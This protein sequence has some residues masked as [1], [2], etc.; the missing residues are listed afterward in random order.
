MN[1]FGGYSGNPDIECFLL[2]NEAYFVDMVCSHS[3]LLEQYKRKSSEVLRIAQR[4]IYPRIGLRLAS[5]KDKE[6]NLLIF[7]PAALSLTQAANSAYDMGR[8]SVYENVITLITDINSPFSEGI[9]NVAASL[10][11]ALL[12]KQ[13]PLN[14]DIKNIDLG[15]SIEERAF[16]DLNK[17][18]EVFNI[19]KDGNIVPTDVPAANRAAQSIYIALDVDK[20][21]LPA[22]AFDKGL[23]DER[24]ILEKTSND[25]PYNIRALD[26]LSIPDNK[27]AFCWFYISGSSY[28]AANPDITG[29]KAS[30]PSLYSYE[31]IEETFFIKDGY[32]ADDII[33]ILADRINDA[34]LKVD[35][36]NIVPSSNLIVSPNRGELTL[37]Y[38]T[39]PKKKLYPEEADKTYDRKM[40]SFRMLQR[41]NYL[42]FDSRRMSSVINRELF[43]VRFFTADKVALALKKFEADQYPSPLDEQPL[44]S[45]KGQA[46]TFVGN[47]NDSTTYQK[48]DLVNFANGSY[49]ARQ[50]NTDKD[51]TNRTWNSDY[52]AV[53][54]TDATDVS[55]Y[56]YLAQDYIEGLVYGL[57]PN[58]VYLDKKG[59]RSLTIEV[60]QGNLKVLNAQNE[61]TSL[62]PRDPKKT[63]LIDT[64]FFRLAENIFSV[65]G[66]I[67][68]RI[69][70]TNFKDVPEI[71]SLIDPLDGSLSINLSSVSAED[72]ALEI[73]KALHTVSQY[74]DVLAALTL[75]HALQFTAFKTTKTEVKEVID[76]LELPS[77][78]E[79]ATGISG[80]GF[81]GYEN[82]VRELTE[83]RSKARSLIITA[84]LIDSALLTTNKDILTNGDYSVASVSYFKQ[85]SLIQSVKDKVNLLNH[86]RF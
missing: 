44:L 80:V 72:V 1:T 41:Y 59:P 26:Y 20:S 81:S 21:T 67:K 42:V 38:V 84:E 53:L 76:I 68:I 57:V 77:G 74:T 32:G 3:I 13:L 4:Q 50:E 58:Y 15:N 79:I 82:S 23:I 5:A 36:A 55:R 48:G 51:P 73:L 16:E 33:S 28:E 52:W 83:Y 25:V 14:N 60:K 54:Y 27:V 19:T 62:D 11:A 8:I 43:I 69:S 78:L 85:S 45:L 9:T 61:S 37:S 6:T 47:W 7:S 46:I 34:T 2:Q 30:T 49:V 56:K 22:Q 64:F 66:R 12:I 70:S 10:T 71:Y 31:P 29:D 24:I 17:I 39:I 35:P 40:A 75:P 18:V 86:R 65:S 63:H